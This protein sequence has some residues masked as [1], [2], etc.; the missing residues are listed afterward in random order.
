MRIRRIE[1]LTTIILTILYS[2]VIGLIVISYFAKDEGTLG[3]HVL[4]NFLADYLYFL[5]I[6][7]FFLISTLSM[8]GLTNVLFF[9]IG[10]LIT[11]LVYP[12]LRI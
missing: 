5:A 12:R 7:T 3:D 10:I 9:S 1:I 6:P 4:L 8:T 2:L 11:G